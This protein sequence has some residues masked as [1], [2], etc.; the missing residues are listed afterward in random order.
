ME[1]WNNIKDCNS[2]PLVIA[3]IGIN[4][5]GDLNRALK[6]IDSAQESGADLVKLQCFDPNEFLSPSSSYFGIFDECR[7][8][9]SQISQLFLHAER[10]K[11]TLF[12][13]VFDSLNL[14]VLEDVGCG[15]YKIASGD[16][17]HHNLISEVAKT[18]KPVIASTGC[19]TLAEATVVKTLVPEINLAFLH[20]VSNYPATID[21]LNLNMMMSMRDHLQV[22]I[23]FSDHTVGISAAIVATALGARVIEKHFTYDKNEM[24]PD[25]A[26][27]ADPKELQEMVKRIN[28][29][30]QATG[31]SEANLIEGNE[32]RI[33]IRRS[34]CVARSLKAGETL[35]KSDLTYLR[36]G[37]GICASRVES[38]LG[39]TLKHDVG[40][41]IQLKPEMLE[42]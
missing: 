12:A 8:K 30:F 11:I 20:C 17:T 31:S 41:G 13:S 2:A 36:P 27:S 29:A 4:H 28:E 23:G 26:L 18:G 9:P 19:S 10:Q 22:P 3:E 6:L 21:S 42:L 15:L 25:H 16:I 39:K 24:G 35:Q 14:Q 32:T 1:I 33:A 37:D 38:V 7:L 5:G 40:P 34:I